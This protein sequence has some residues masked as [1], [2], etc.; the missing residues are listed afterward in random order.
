MNERDLQARIEVVL[1]HIDT[2]YL[3]LLVRHHNA[4]P[5][6]RVWEKLASELEGTWIAL[7]ELQK[8]Y[9]DLFR[10]HIA[11]DFPIFWQVISNR[12]FQQKHS[13]VTNLLEISA[14]FGG[15]TM[16]DALGITSLE[17]KQ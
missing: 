16:A 3:E 8:W 1:K 10:S 14:A 7:T 13:E 6:S 2:T 15:A 4:D 9:R 11:T 12:A 17:R 5:D